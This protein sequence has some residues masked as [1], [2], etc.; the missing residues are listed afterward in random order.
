MLDVKD[1]KILKELLVDSRMSISRLAKKVGV[2]REVA[3]YRI[4]KLKKEMIKEFY[5]VIDTKALGYTR[6]TTFIQL[7]GI[8]IEQEKIFLNELMKDPA[9][10]YMG[11]VMGK[12]NVVFDILAKDATGDPILSAPNVGIQVAGPS[13]AIEQS[14]AAVTAP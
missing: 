5:T 1:K 12:W 2:S 6:Y 8:T 10:T 14:W 11:P 7:K 4:N 13:K 3:L 9:V